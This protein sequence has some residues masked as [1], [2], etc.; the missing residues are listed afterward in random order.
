MLVTLTAT[1]G[2]VLP[3]ST[4]FTYLLCNEDIKQV[5]FLCESVSALVTAWSFERSFDCDIIN[6]HVTCNT[7]VDV[8]WRAC[9]L[10]WW[11][12]QFDLQSPAWHC[13]NYKQHAS[14]LVVNDCLSE[15]WTI[16]RVGHLLLCGLCNA[17]CSVWDCESLQWDT[18]VWSA[19]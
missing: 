3:T 17:V 6:S 9:I 11:S 18:V 14:Q 13:Y 15:L 4:R 12:D 2:F 19:V 8:C 16:A 1:C 10:T 7:F 5:L